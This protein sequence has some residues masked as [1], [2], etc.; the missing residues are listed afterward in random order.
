MDK[1]LEICGKISQFWF[2]PLST[3]CLNNYPRIL[4]SDEIVLKIVLCLWLRYIFFFHFWEFLN[5]Y[6]GGYHGNISIAPPFQLPWWW[7]MGCQYHSA[8]VLNSIT[9]ATGS[10]VIFQMIRVFFFFL[11]L[12]SWSDRSLFFPLSNACPRKK[13]DPQAPC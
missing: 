13:A 3:G 4:F 1:Y 9:I 2:F 7:V 6:T 10:S 8:I 12:M 11:L 5:N